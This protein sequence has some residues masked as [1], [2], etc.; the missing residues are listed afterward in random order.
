MKRVWNNGIDRYSYYEP[1]EQPEPEYRDDTE[2]IVLDLDAIIIMD[3]DGFWE[4][5][6]TEYPW[7]K[8]N[9]YSED[10]WETE[11]S[12]YPSMDLTTVD[13]VVEHTDELLE[14]LLP[15]AAGR[16]HISGTVKLVYTVEGVERY[17]EYLGRGYHDEDVID[18][19]YFTEN[20]EINFQ[21]DQSSINNFEIEEL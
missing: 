12:E 6:D 11:S 17:E 14:P 20:A 1:P 13:E 16:Y 3:K 9:G 8:G 2:E 7:A 15:F 10:V 18:E 5:E 4:Y 21:Y 19:E